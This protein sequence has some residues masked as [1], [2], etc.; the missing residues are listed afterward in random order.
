M[1]H[2]VKRGC[3]VRNDTNNRVSFAFPHIYSVTLSDTDLV[4]GKSVLNRIDPI[5]PISGSREILLQPGG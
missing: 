3:D 4:S 1:S 2:D 5:H